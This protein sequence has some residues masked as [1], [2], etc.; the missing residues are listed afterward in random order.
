[1]KPMTNPAPTARRVLAATLT[2]L[3]AV[4]FASGQTAAETI[5]RLQEENAALRKQLADF[6]A[7][8]VTAPAI[9]PAA[10]A[11][12][13]RTAPATT[14]TTT[15]PSATLATD[16]GVQTL[17][18]FEVRS[19]KDFGY[20]RTN[21][22]TATRIGT[23]IQE[24]P[25][26]IQVVSDEFI[27]DLNFTEISDVLRY[28]ATAA[29]DNQMGV[30]QPAT[31]FTPS[32]NIS[33]RGFPINA[34]LRNSVKRYSL[35]N[36]DNV[37][38]VELIRGPA[39][40]FFG[41]SFPG[42]VINY[43]TK[44]PEFRQI[45]TS[46][47]YMTSYDGENKAT[48]DQNTVLMSN[49]L[50]FRNFLSWENS[51]FQRDFEF[52]RGFTIMP[53]VK[54]RVLDNLTLLGEIEY[55]QRAENIDSYTWIWPRGWFEAYQNPTV[56]LMNAGNIPTVQNGATLSLAQRQ[57]LYR[58]RIGGQNYTVWATDM[59]TALGDQGIPIHTAFRDG[60]VASAMAP[61]DFNVHGR[62]TLADEKS[63]TMSFTADYAPLPWLSTRYHFNRSHNY[64]YERKA[65]ARPNA[66]GET[67]NTLVGL[68]WRFY[69]QEDKNHILDNVV[70]LDFKGIKNKILFGGIY[71]RTEQKYGGQYPAN[72][73][74]PGGIDYSLIPGSTANP[75][76]V[77]QSLF[78]RRGNPLT[79][80]QVFSNYDPTI[81]TFP[82]I[83]RITERT[84]DVIDRYLP[85][86]IERYISYQ[87]SLF[88]NRLH[89]MAGYRDEKTY[90]R[91]QQL[92]TNPPWLTG[93]EDMLERLTPADLFRYQ[94]S[95]SYQ[96]SLLTDVTGDSMMYGAAFNV[97]PDITLYASYS[98]S[99]LPNGG[100]K[101]IYNEID[102]RARATQLGRNPD[103]EVAR[104]RAEGSD[105][106]LSNEDGTNMEVGVKTSLFDSKIVGTLSLFRLE[107]TNRRVDDGPRQN[108][109]PLNYDQNGV[110]TGN[111][112]R[113]F[114]ADATQRTEGTE[115]EVIWTPSR[116]YQLVGAA[117]WMW[118]A[119]TVSDPS[120]LPN[121]VN[122]NATFRGRLVYAPEYT[123]KVWNKYTVSEGNLAGFTFG[124]GLRYAS[125]IV[126]S[127]SRDWDATRGGL[128]AGDYAVFDGLIGY[129]TRI[130]GVPT[131]FGLSGQNL[132]D[133]EYSEGGWN[134]ARGRELSL[135]GRITF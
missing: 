35:Y 56:E 113:W 29:G 85:R 24:T 101:A 114:S 89:L 44:Q 65:Q 90:H 33:T 39:S 60:P 10:P 93:F 111:I 63:T 84:R 110:R 127:A 106:V 51:R 107:R 25:L 28:S 6:Q 132:L 120:I 103:A 62:G 31:G 41:Q 69:D 115:A 83:A 81:H 77:A 126:I 128:T 2:A 12:P 47:S 99:Y 3:L 5:R 117:G 73:G 43:V 34:R 26:Q 49:K 86:T 102:V 71:R 20:L 32:G 36:L 130:W 104:I 17:T 91:Q 9:Q 129:S 119:K 78:D 50:A 92:N 134:L 105:S 8:G 18:P 70:S 118:T 108:D 75:V 21:S 98:Q 4:P 135:T 37:E 61:D 82:D 96:R 97:R 123:L 95:E 42:G 125:E 57:A 16:A 76:Y 64:Y 100:F 116:N 131:Y 15:A 1:M 11:A 121:N 94:I 27:Q 30:L 124:L 80:Q 52:R 55:T 53:Q 68:A 54:A 58:T 14:T 133:K 74:V 88:D 22:V 72:V 87:G 109:E 112:V 38:R 40:V 66:D 19:E 7:R 45:P 79:A 13:G 59:R 67:Y 122:Y 23:P 48:I 46:M